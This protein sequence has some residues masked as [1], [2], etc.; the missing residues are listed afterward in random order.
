MVPLWAHMMP[1]NQ[2]PSQLVPAIPG[3]QL[4]GLQ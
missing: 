4:M 2:G 1:G 3:G